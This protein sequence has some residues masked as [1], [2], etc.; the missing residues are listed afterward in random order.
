M[1]N[2]FDER[3]PDD[4]VYEVDRISAKKVVN[5]PSRPRRDGTRRQIT[6]YLVHWVGQTALRDCWVREEDCVGCEE[7]IQEFEQCEAA[8][9]P[10]RV[11]L[12]TSSLLPFRF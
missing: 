8:R 2:T 4:I 6:K 10:R 9:H 11:Y 12:S 5:A 3:F 7:A 1:K